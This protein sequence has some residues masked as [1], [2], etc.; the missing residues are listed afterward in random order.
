MDLYLLTN[1]KHC[2]KQCLNIKH[3]H[4]WKDGIHL[5]EKGKNILANNFIDNLQ[6]YFLLQMAEPPILT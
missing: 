6:N 2:L 4:L 5:N 1:I 3:Y